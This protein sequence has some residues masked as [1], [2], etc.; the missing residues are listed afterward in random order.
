[1]LVYLNEKEF[2]GLSKDEQ[3]RVH[4]ECGA[5]HEALVKSGQSIGATGLQPSSSA[6]TLRFKN[7]KPNITDGP[8][9]ET[10]EI[11]AGVE[12]FDFTTVEEAIR[13]LESFPDLNSGVVLE[14]R[15][16]V[17]NNRCEA[18]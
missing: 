13:T 15:P 6:K 7:G 17:P 4:R 10:K 12:I 2:Y 8:Y 1:M 5:W 9:A 14:L 18:V 11:I 16:L 3:N